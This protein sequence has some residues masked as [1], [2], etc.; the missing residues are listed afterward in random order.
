MY[1]LP[2]LRGEEEVGQIEA[3]DFSEYVH[4]DI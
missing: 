3:Y 2:L 1:E 4:L